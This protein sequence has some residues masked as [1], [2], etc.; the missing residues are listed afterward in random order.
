MQDVYYDTIY[1]LVILVALFALLS[2]LVKNRIL[3][4]L[5]WIQDM[6]LDDTFVIK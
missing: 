5:T 1:C 6:F 2:K 4:N 3:T